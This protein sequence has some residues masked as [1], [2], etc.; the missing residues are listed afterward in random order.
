VLDDQGLSAL[1]I[2]AEHA[3][4]IRRLPELTRHDPSI[5]CSSLERASRWNL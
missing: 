1:D 4:T 3:D 5:G 2:T